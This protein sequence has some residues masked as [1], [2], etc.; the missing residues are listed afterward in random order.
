MAP[1]WLEIPPQGYGGIE[2]VVNNLVVEY[3]KMGVDVELF[4]VG[5]STTPAAKIHSIYPHGQYHHIQ[6]P[7][8]Y[9]APIAITQIMLALETIAADGKFDIIH[10]HNGF[11]GPAMMGHL[12]GSYPP[13]LHTLHGPFSNDQLVAEDE[14]DNRPMYKYFGGLKRLYINGIS[15]AQMKDAPAE[16]EPRV[17]G[18]VYN[19]VDLDSLPYTTDKSDYFVT[20]GRFNRDKNQALA[21]KLCRDL[22]Y[23]L[24]MIG[25]VAGI[26]DPAELDTEMSNPTN[27]KANTGDFQYFKR[28]VYPLL[29]PGQIEFMGGVPDSEKVDLLRH[30]KALLFPINWEEPFGM[31]V[32]EA[33]ACGTP[34][35]SMRRGAI[36]EIIEHGV[37][38]WLADTEAEFKEYMQRV[39]EID[40][41]VCRKSVEDK[42]SSRKM[43]ENY[44]E[45]YRKVMAADKK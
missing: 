40:P 22:G 44:L 3:G 10:D 9:A 25:G 6:K 2:F 15:E 23:K 34:V 31:A 43:A 14:P 8:Y 45:L 37:N 7:F 12:D 24:K 5:N 1:P 38:G 35:V 32:I 36:P 19:A 11:I 39:D 20:L 17:A 33:M 42:F 21:A 29:V 16:L 28:Q 26:V 30:A 27:A 4:T 13:V 18:V 41:A